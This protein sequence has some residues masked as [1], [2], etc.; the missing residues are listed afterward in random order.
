MLTTVAMTFSSMGLTDRGQPLGLPDGS[1]RAVI[2]LSLVVLFAIFTIFLYRG[3]FVG[4]PLN[5]IFLTQA[6]MGQFF[7]RATVR[8]IR[9][10]PAVDR[11][12]QPLKNSDSIQL[13][14]VNFRESE[15]AASAD[16]A[17]Q[18]LVLLGTLMTAVTSFY[19]GAGTATSAAAGTAQGPA[20]T[21]T[22]IDP[23]A[24]SI[25]ND[26]SPIHLRVMGSN[27]NP[28]TQVKIVRAGVP[29][30]GIN[31]ASSPTGVTCDIPV[32]TT[33]TPPGLQPWDVVVDDGASK[34]ATLPGALTISA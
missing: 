31:V 10:K 16:F 5:T 8:E 28:I 3:I 9:T 27:L 2:A 17:K 15:T 25:S 22:G 4:G 11:D 26:G 23:I 18:L 32:S 34:S 7:N 30:F 12:N 20:P 14:E 21:L 29:V 6:E 1:I 24:H 13:Y 19:L 33:T